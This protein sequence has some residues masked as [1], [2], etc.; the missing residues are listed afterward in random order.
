MAITSEK[1]EGK[2]ISVDIVSS[3]I[4]GATFNTETSVLQITFNYG[5]IYQYEGIPWELFAKFRMSDSQG[6]FF[7]THIKT[8][9]AHKKMN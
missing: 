9:Y 1:I 5:G 7:N 4:K 8:K 2:I 6:S 3:N